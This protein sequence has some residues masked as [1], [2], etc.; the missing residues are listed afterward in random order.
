MRLRK[1]INGKPVIGELK[2]KGVRYYVD[3]DKN[4]LTELDGEYTRV[5][6]E[7]TLREI[8][9]SLTTRSMDVR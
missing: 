5:T 8:L 1:E 3:M 9:D 2:V 6:D 7:A 4:I